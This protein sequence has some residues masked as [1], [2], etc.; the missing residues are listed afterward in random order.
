VFA[1]FKTCG[2]AYKLNYIELIYEDT[3][4]GTIKLDQWF[5]DDQITIVSSAGSKFIKFSASD[6][7]V[8][9][10]IIYLKEIQLYRG[11]M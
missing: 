8:Y 2:A 1:A 5:S 4:T 6:N 7:A 10:T 3:S 9:P 11:M